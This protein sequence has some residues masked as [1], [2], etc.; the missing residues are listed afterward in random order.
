MALAVGRRVK[1]R[2]FHRD[3]KTK[4][5]ELLWAEAVGPNEFQ[6]DSPWHVDGY[7]CGDVVSGVYEST[8]KVGAERNIP[9]Y[10]CTGILRKGPFRTIRARF[11]GQSFSSPARAPL[12]AAL[13]AMAVW[14]EMDN[15]VDDKTTAVWFTKDV[16]AQA[17]AR[18][19]RDAGAEV[20]FA[21]VPD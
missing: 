17:V 19:L 5:S 8:T 1:V 6:L 11:Q 10:K 20:H 4:G 21:D 14:F 3:F 12:R 16:D 2:L 18:V 13:S 9:V 7:S 15:D